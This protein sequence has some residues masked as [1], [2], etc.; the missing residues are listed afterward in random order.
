[1]NL[2]LTI[3]G[4]GEDLY[5]P[6]SSTRQGPHLASSL[7]FL[8]CLSQYLEHARDF[9][10]FEEWM[11]GWMNAWML[12]MLC[13]K[14]CGRTIKLDKGEVQSPSLILF[15]WINFIEFLPLDLRALVCAMVRWSYS[16]FWEDH[17]ALLPTLNHL[18][19]KV[20]RQDEC[21]WNLK[22]H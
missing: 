3:L 15:S 17:P 7:S 2:L 14:T 21:R 13:T 9:I 16:C 6:I 1:M 19:K 8:Q 11:S 5:L 18:L 12:R 20:Q 10:F 4:E 22:L